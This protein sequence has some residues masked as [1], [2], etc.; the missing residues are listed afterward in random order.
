MLVSLS[1]NFQIFPLLQFEPYVTPGNEGIVHHLLVYECYGNFS[2]ATLHGSGFDC[3]ETPNMPLGHCYGYSVVAAWAVGGTVRYK[4]YK[5]D[6]L[7][8]GNELLI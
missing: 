1:E 3:H 5:L 6:L 2:N 7:I 8:L 4:T